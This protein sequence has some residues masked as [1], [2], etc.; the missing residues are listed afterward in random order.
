M[1]LRVS[2]SRRGI[3]LY[4][5]IMPGGWPQ[6][7]SIE[8]TF[9]GRHQYPSSSIAPRLKSVRDVLASTG[10]D[11]LALSLRPPPPSFCRDFPRVSWDLILAKVARTALMR[12]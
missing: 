5:G 9:N 11:V 12:P 4:F 1:R 6:P 7:D 3:L 10:R 8:Q 2:Y